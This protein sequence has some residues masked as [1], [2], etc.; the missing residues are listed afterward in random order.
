M[1]EVQPA[2][3]LRQLVVFVLDKEEYAV[4]IHEVRE[5]LKI[6]KITPV[7]NS[8]SFILGVINLR[9]KIVP[10]LDVEKRF[11]LVRD[12]TG[13]VPEHV[14]ITEGQDGTPFGVQVDRVSGVLK[15]PENMIQPTPEMVKSRISADYLGGVIVIE[16][17]RILLLLNVQKILTEQVQ[18]LLKQVA[19]GESDQ[20]EHENSHS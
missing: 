1:T 7:P 14:M 6:P 2:A 13:T 16:S 9:G 4:P 18:D 19:T 5:V 11:N 15:V 8:P 12:D 20:N 10:V 3:A 17:E